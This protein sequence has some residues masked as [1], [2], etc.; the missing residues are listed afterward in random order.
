MEK[1]HFSAGGA[2]SLFFSAVLIRTFFEDIAYRSTKTFFTTDIRTLIHYSL[3]YF[4][5]ILGLILIIH[6][7]SKRNILTVTGLVLLCSP[8]IITP[9]LI[10]LFLF[11]GVSG[12]EMSYLFTGVNGLIK[13]FF[14]FYQVDELPR[15]PMG[16]RVEFVFI[17][18]GM[19]IYIRT[20][21][22]SL[23]RS[24]LGV[25]SAYVFLFVLCTLPSVIALGSESSQWYFLTTQKTSLLSQ[26][27]F[28][29]ELKFA[30]IERAFEMLFNGAMTL[31]LYFISLPL[32]FL[33]A[34][35]YNKNH[36]LAILKNARPERILHYSS[37]ICIG[38]LLGVQTQ[39]NLYF[40]WISLGTIIC[41]FLSFWFAWMYAVGVNDC[42]DVESDAL[43]NPNRPLVTGTITITD[44][45]RSNKIFL[46]LAILGGYLA[47]NVVLFMVVLF[48]ALSHIYSSPPLKLKRFLGVNS[49]ILGLCALITFIAGYSTLALEKTI[50]SIPSSWSLLILLS[51]TLIANVKDIKDIDG[52][53]RVHVYTIPVVFGDAL[54]KKIISALIILALLLP[55]FILKLPNLFL[56]V[57]FFGY[58]AMKLIQ[59]EPFKEKYVF[60][61][62]FAYLILSFFFIF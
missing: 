18:I 34:L 14:T 23:F 39:Q 26:N 11:K 47:G 6:L 46:L 5:A 42:I 17:F 48:I 33:Y 36:V 32:L 57:P 31:V 43:S 49:L 58:A 28:H 15:M 35:R 29:P 20:Y 37:M 56:F 55:P 45:E 51:V 2:A 4:V 21:T 24:V 61:L 27:F 41:L 60:I 44:V 16:V 22:S 12:N 59:R 10:D 13:N 53:R 8:I 40:N 62:Y 19:F 30:N 54:G 38:L 1:V 50:D 25:F 9:P 3:F 52:D 7:F